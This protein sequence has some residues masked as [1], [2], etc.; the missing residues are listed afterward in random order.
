[1]SDNAVSVPAI[2]TASANPNELWRNYTKNVA[3]AACTLTLQDL[4]RLYRIINEKQVALGEMLIDKVYSQLPSETLEQFNQR[5][6]N[7]KNAFITT[8]TIAGANG[9]KVI[10]PGENI[11]TSGLIPARM[12]SIL[13][14]TSFSPKAILNYTPANRASVFLDFSRP[15]LLNFVGHPSAPTP[16]NSNWFV[17]GDTESWSTSMSARI[18][19]FFSERE[20]QVGWLHQSATY[21]WLLLVLGFPFSLWSAHRLGDAVTK[22]TAL[23]G[24]L[25]TAVYIYAFIVALSIFRALFSYARWVF[26]KIELASERS[27][28]RTHRFIWSGLVL[29]I[30]AGAAWDFIKAL[31]G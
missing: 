24:I 14:D 17:T 7:A 28:V 30:L 31:A 26:P 20:T 13:Y 10:G 5:S 11:F 2:D 18:S 1:M 21:D 3:I 15:P 8:V 29:G 19:D 23:P 16:N 4:Q 9:E 25:S 12:E 27:T 6:R 22:Y